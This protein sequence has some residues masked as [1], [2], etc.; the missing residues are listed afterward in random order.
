MRKTRKIEVRGDVAII[1][2]TRGHSAI[3]DAVDVDL[4]RKINWWASSSKSTSYARGIQ[5]AVP[6]EGKGEYVYLHRIIISA[7]DGVHVDHINHDG[8]DNRRDNL[9]L[10]NVSENI[11]NAQKR[12]DN[13]SGFKGVSWE[14]IGRK[15][16][17]Q[18]R[19]RGKKIHLGSFD[20]PEDAHQAYS[21]AS[22]E[23]H[24]VYGFNGVSSENNQEP[25]Q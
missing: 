22:Q 5:Q 10:C 25:S 11:M 17:A 8:L 15:W 24:G 6:G 7:P 19:S 21:R 18:I 2:L 14:K 13:K 20:S 3:I 4:V 9:R 12:S 23:M 16:R 1:P